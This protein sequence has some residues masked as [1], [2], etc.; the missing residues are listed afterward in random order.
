MQ[1]TTAALKLRRSILELETRQIQEGQELKEQLMITYESLKP[2]NVLK[3]VIRDIAGPT[4]LKESLVQTTAGLI[5]G[6]I[7]RKLIIRSS[8][9]PF[10][11]LAG[12]FIQFG[13]TNFVS[14]HAEAITEF[15][16]YLIDKLSALYPHRKN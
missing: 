16:H 6:Y 15:G 3:K 9:N 11:R 1:K 2:I 5:T 12:V 7:S 14:N 10:V 8:R 13:V 4:D